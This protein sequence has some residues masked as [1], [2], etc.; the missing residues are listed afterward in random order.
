VDGRHLP[1]KDVFVTG[2]A[3][4]YPPTPEGGETRPWDDL[5]SIEANVGIAGHSIRVTVGFVDIVDIRWHS[6]DTA[7][8]LETVRLY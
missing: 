4:S 7:S 1:A 3:N 5:E 6:D 8:V 2:I